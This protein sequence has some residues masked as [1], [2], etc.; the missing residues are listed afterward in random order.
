MYRFG[1][2]LVAVP[3]ALVG[4]G[5]SEQ[6]APEVSAAQ[7][8][9][10]KDRAQAFAGQSVEQLAGNA[11][12]MALAGELVEGHCASCH[13]K[14][15]ASSGIPDLRTAMFNFGNSADAI[16][17]TIVNGRQNVMPAFGRTLG[18]SDI[19]AMAQ[20][21][22]TLGDTEAASGFAKTAI[23]LY[24]ENCVACHG[25]MGEGNPQIGIPNLADDYWQ[26][27]DNIIQLRMVITRGLDEACPPHGQA[28]DAAQVELLTA[29]LSQR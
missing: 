2:L 15:S 13:A 6:A 20:Y 4:C 22:R 10:L 26:H 5:G 18:E 25:A 29:Y 19:G 3:L 23:D 16:R 12:A 21:L 11:E 17:E 7:L 24:E 14:A 27:G 1:L 28:L 9:Q 8:T